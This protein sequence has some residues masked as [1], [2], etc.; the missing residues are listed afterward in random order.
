MSTKEAK[1]HL[2][3]AKEHIDKQEYKDALKFLKKAL[4]IDNSNY[5]ALVFIAYCLNK[6]GESQQVSW[7]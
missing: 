6:T 4:V 3:T 1:T 5:T 2:R 7:N